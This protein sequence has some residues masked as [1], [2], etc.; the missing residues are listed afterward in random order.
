M[1]FFERGRMVNEVADVETVYTTIL[2]ADYNEEQDTFDVVLHYQEELPAEPSKPICGWYPVGPLAAQLEG[3]RETAFSAYG[4][5]YDLIV[6]NAMRGVFDELLGRGTLWTTWL[7]EEGYGEFVHR[8]SEAE[9]AGEVY[10][11]GRR[12]KVS[13]AVIRD[14]AC[15][16][17]HEAR[18]QQWTDGESLRSF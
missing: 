3:K 2:T 6:Y 17:L 8:L 13:E 15:A 4:I 5:P 12:D 14:E 10:L 1:V 16:Y 11:L 7:E 18:E 9:K